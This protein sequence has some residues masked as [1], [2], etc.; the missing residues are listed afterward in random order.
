VT[1]RVHA[2]VTPLNCLEVS[3]GIW[4]RSTALARSRRMRGEN[5]LRMKSSVPILSPNNSSIS[6][7]FKERKITGVNKHP[8]GP[9]SECQLPL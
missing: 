2:K 6:S 9:P 5:G 4:R 3:F 1:L 8:S 7:S